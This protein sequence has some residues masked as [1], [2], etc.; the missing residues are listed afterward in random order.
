MRGLILALMVFGN[1]CAGTAQ[2]EPLRPAFQPAEPRSVADIQP[3]DRCVETGT[4]V[5]NVVINETGKVQEVEVRRNIPCLTQ[6]AVQAVKEW[7]FSPAMLAGKPIA[8]RMPVAVT[9]ESQRS[10]P[11]PFPLPKLI[12]QTAAAVQAEFQPAEVTRAGFPPF[13]P[14]YTL[15]MRAVVLEV[16]L[17]V[18]GEAEEIKVLRDLPPFTAPAKAVVGDWRFTPATFN[19]HPIRSKVL[20]AFVSPLLFMPVHEPN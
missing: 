14:G 4:V 13:H 2:N 3:Y 8:S 11:N 9:F 1:V 5:L 20:L 10:A 19:G 7:V 12:P 15:A 6:V 16:T 17:S 18:K